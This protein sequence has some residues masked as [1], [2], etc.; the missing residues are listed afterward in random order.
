VTTPAE[1]SI[2]TV[3]FPYADRD[4]VKARPALVVPT[5]RFHQATGLSWV[6]MITSALHVPWDGDFAIADLAKAGLRTPSIVRTAKIATVDIAR[7]RVIG[8][9]AVEQR[10]TIHD[11]VTSRIAGSG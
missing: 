7:L 1:W 11:V 6:L 3:P 10:A 8:T 9:L 5:A 4:A 2:V